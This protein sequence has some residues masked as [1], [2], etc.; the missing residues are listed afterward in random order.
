LVLE[1]VEAMASE[2]P[3]ATAADRE[4]AEVEM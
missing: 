2:W 4:G 3:M 1:E